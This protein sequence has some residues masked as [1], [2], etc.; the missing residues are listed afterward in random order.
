M[1]T[2]DQVV[3]QSDRATDVSSDGGIARAL[4]EEFE[5]ELGTARRF[6]ERV[7]ED[8]LT[9]R[10]H[11]RSMTTGQL[12]LHIANI[13]AGVLKM[14]LTDEA[15]APDFSRARQQPETLREVLDSLEGSAAF[16][17]QTLPTVDDGRMCKTVKV[18]QADRTLMSLPR[19]VF[20]RSLMLN[21]W[22]HHRGQLGVYLRLVGA[23]VPSSYGPSGDA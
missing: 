22:Y 23:A 1:K 20:L 16:V 6:L 2:T 12:A 4:L 15:T 19:H 3:A 21:H 13:P 5:R 10:P 7:R 18:V 14:A 9:W 8:R 17:R 11:E